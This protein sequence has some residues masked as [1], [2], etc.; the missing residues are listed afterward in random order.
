MRMSRTLCSWLPEISCSLSHGSGY[1]QS[2]GRMDTRLLSGSMQAQV[3]SFF[4]PIKIK[5]HAAG[6]R[7]MQGWEGEEAESWT[8][9]SGPSCHADGLRGRD[10]RGGRGRRLEC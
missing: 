9:E 6:F 1:S 4:I 8:D 7:A 5:A 10:L 3:G 2:E